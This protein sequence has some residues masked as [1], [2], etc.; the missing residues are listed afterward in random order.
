MARAKNEHARELSKLGAAKGGQV[1]ASRL[2]QEERSAIAREAAERRWGTAV[3]RAT[4][5]G[6]IVIAGRSLSCA[7]LD[8][9]KRVLTQGTFLKALGRVRTPK[10]GTG[11]IGS[12]GSL[13]FFLSAGNIQP[14]V[15]DEMKEAAA[16]IIYRTTTGG[17]GLGY[18]A[19][20]L[21]MVCEAYLGANDFNKTLKSQEQIVAA[22]NLLVRGLAR[23]G[24]VAL[25]DEATGYQEERA[26]DELAKILE[27]YIAAELMPWVKR[28][29]D[30]FFQHIYRLQ[31]WEYKPGSA[32][33][34]PLV[35]HLINQ[36]VYLQLPPGVLDELRRQNPIVMEGHRRYKHHQFLT[37][38]TGHVHLDKQ[39]SI[40]MTLMRIS[41]DKDEFEELFSR[42]F[43]KGVQQRLPLVI[44]VPPG[45]QA[46]SA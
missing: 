34:T 28:F 4:H 8:N 1:R 17:R 21:P 3:P 7:V 19:N 35:G 27:H 23:V 13:P 18:D 37:P 25:V 15:S 2:S 16:P 6:E 45:Q 42:A 26:K 44:D 10:A 20:L 14:F 9:G 41:A 30:E 32:K 29:P 38:S 40:V 12:G 11:I 22:C 39:I 36:Y 24:I 5:T 46:D 43:G 33:R 31:G